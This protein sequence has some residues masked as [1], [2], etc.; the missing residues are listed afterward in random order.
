MNTCICMIYIHMSLYMLIH[1][2][3]YICMYA[4]ICT[5]TCMDIYTYIYIYMIYIYI[6]TYPP[7]HTHTYSHT[8]TRA[9]AH[10]H[11]YHEP[12]HL[13]FT[14]CP[15]PHIQCANMTCD[16]ELS[17]CLNVLLMSRTESS[18]TKLPQTESFKCHEL[19]ILVHRG[20]T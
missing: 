17:P 6:H 7:L 8:H 16:N 20:R 5:Y 11:A 1:I 14:N 9:H 18:W 19:T 4:Y 2:L 12:G 13:N 3:L 10:T 15:Y